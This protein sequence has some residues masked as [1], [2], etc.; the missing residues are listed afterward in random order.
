MSMI[1][2]ELIEHRELIRSLEYV[3]G[4]ALET[5]YVQVTV[6]FAT[7]KNVVFFYAYHLN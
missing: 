4:I 3:N 5:R 1:V 6:F 7:S 2:M